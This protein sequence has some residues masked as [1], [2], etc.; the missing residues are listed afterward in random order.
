MRTV[1]SGRLGGRCVCPAG[2]AG[3]RWSAW[4]CT[5]PTSVKRILDTRL[6]KH[7]LSA[8]SFADGNNNQ[9]EL[10]CGILSLLDIIY[11]LLQK[12]NKFIPFPHIYNI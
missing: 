9:Y 10:E 3:G 7:Y 8:T 5:S 2:S 12:I 6:W 1:C 4:G 11:I